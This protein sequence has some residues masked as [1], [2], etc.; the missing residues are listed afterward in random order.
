MQIICIFVAFLRQLFSLLLF[1][2]DSRCRRI[3]AS[4]SALYV[5]TGYPVSSL[6]FVSRCSRLQTPRARPIQDKCGC[7]AMRSV[8]G[9]L[10]AVVFLFLL[11]GLCPFC[12]LL[13]GVLCQLDRHP[14]PVCVVRCRGCYPRPPFHVV[15]TLSQRVLNG[16]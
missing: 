4:L 3:T 10:P 8:A 9:C 11:L 1:F 5:R 6:V 13:I 16:C 12:R 2:W 7:S 15:S 14:M